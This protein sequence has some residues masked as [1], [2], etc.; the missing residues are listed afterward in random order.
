MT[1]IRAE[2]AA[3]VDRLAE[4]AT[5]S[6]GVTGAGLDALEPAIRTAMTAVGARLLG[7]LLSLDAGYRGPRVDCG[8]GH[9]AGFVS[10]RVKTIDTVLGPVPVRRAYYHCPACRAG[11]VPRDVELGVERTSMTPGLHAMVAHTATVVP[12]AKAAGMLAELAGIRLSTKRVERAAEADGAA[13]RA[14]TQAE[15]AAIL[16]GR[17]APL[18][19]AGDTRPDMLYIAI[20][21]TGVPMRPAE[22]A[23]R[24][25]KGPDGRARTREVKLACLFT[26]TSRDAADHPVRDPDSS[27]YLASFEPAEPFGALVAAEA[28]RR[29]AER[30][31]QLLV[32]GD[33]APWIWKLATTRF[34]EATQ[35]VDL[36]HAREHIHDLADHLAFIVYDP[37]AWLAER[38]ADLDAGDIAAIIHAARAYPLVGTK[39]KDLNTKIGYFETNAE[40]MRYAYFRDLGMFVGSGTVEAGCK[41]VIGARMK[42]SGMRWTIH[43]ADA[44]SHLRCQDAS[45]RWDQIWTMIHNQTNTA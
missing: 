7:D 29:G 25:G 20:D 6:A 22:T 3:E 34:P 42:Q 23:G 27:T 19:P 41:S 17:V 30:I 5:R 24:A 35:I 37:A 43:G 40:R 32:L 45:D 11:V 31:R 38:L 26:Q 21:G 2:F 15:S 16:A 33:G 18:P 14:A 4:L 36:Y 13:A 9:Q 44:I 8:A 12:F 39:A 28:R 1:A 10:Y